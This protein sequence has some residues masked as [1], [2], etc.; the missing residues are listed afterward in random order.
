[1]YCASSVIGL[2]NGV[3]PNVR[4]SHCADQMEV[5][6]VPTELEPLT[7]IEELDVL[8]SSN[9]SLTAVSMNNHVSTVL[10]DK[11]SL[12]ISL[13]ENVSCEQPDLSSHFDKLL[14]EPLNAGVV[15]G[16]KSRVQSDHW[17]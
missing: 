13:D 10:V 12:W 15:L 4:L 7:Y 6:G 11:R 5:N 2:V 16:L 1:M 9:D 14:V 8:D 3:S 17:L